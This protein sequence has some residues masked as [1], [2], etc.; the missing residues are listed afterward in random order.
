MLTLIET[1]NFNAYTKTSSIILQRSKSSCWQRWNTVIHPVIK[2]YNMKDYSFPDNY[3][4]WKTDALNY[5]IQNRTESLND[6]DYQ[7]MLDDVCPGQTVYSLKKFLKSLV[8]EKLRREKNA[9]KS[10]LALYKLAEERLSTKQFEILNNSTKKID[11]YI[12]LC[13]FY[14]ILLNEISNV[15]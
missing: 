9:F 3:V 2:T 12:E 13:D 11:R 10:E 1:H 6:F 7:K 15:K 4:D 14:R 5:V 8:E